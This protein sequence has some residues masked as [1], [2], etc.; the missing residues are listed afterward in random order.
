LFKLAKEAVREVEIPRNIKTLGIL[1]H[2]DVVEE[3]LQTDSSQE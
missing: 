1:T 2:E 3:V